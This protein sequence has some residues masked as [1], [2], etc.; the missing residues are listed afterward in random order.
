MA[1][2]VP[3]F[4][5]YYREYFIADHRRLQKLFLLC[6]RTALVGSR[7]SKSLGW[8][9]HPGSTGFELQ[10]DRYGLVGNGIYGLLLLSWLVVQQVQSAE[11]QGGVENFT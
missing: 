6:E 11:N 5:C 2:H 7:T 10:L 4:C 3:F 1:I 9:G 8:V